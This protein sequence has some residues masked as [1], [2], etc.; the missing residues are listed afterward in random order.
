[1]KQAIKEYVAWMGIAMYTGACVC[2]AV[3][4]ITAIVYISKYK[5]DN[6]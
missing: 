4:G 1:M 6:G 2:G 5:I 3:M